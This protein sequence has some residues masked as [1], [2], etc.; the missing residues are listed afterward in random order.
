MDV[1]LGP[2]KLILGDLQ[3]MNL[4]RVR[5]RYGL[6]FSISGFISMLPSFPYLKLPYLLQRT[7]ECSWVLVAIVRACLLV[8]R[9]VEEEAIVTA[10]T[11]ASRL[12]FVHRGGMI[13]EPN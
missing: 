8:A 10:M 3:R 12:D 13:G 7:H 4:E 5:G 6:A 2:K 11:D 9:T 1:A